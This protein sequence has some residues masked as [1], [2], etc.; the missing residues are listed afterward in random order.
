MR[1]SFH[2]RLILA[3]LAASCVLAAQVA[4]SR[5]IGPPDLADPPKPAQPQPATQPQNAPP[6]GA[7]RLTDS[8]A[9]IMPNASLTEM[10][11]LLAKRLKI[12][13]ILDPAV[14][15]TVSIFTYGEVKP[16]DYMP[17]LETI[18]RVNGSAMVKV[19]DIYRIVPVNRINQL[20]L[21]P[22]VNIDPKTLPDDERMVMN[23]IFLK[24]ATAAEI[25][26]LVKPFLGEGAFVSV[27]EPANLLLIE[28]NARSMK[29]TMDLIALFDSDQ[30]AGQR[31]RLFEVENSRPSDLQHELDLVFKA[32]ALSD[33]AAGSVK[34]IPVDRINT[35][36]AVAP[37]PGIFTQV[38]NWIGKLDIA[39]KASSGSVNTYVYR[40]KYA[41]A[42]TIAMAIMALYSGNP[43]ALMALGQMASQQNMGAGNGMGGM[44]GGQFGGQMGGG[45][46]YQMMGAMMGGGMG[47]P[48]LGMGGYGYGNQGMGMGGYPQIQQAS[49][50][51]AGVNIPG[52]ANSPI[53]QTGE[54]LGAGMAGGQGN[55][56]VPHVI[57]NPFDNTILIQGTPQEYGQILGLLR[58]LDIPPRQV[59]IDAKIYE[60]DLNGAF[61]A[62]VTAYLE[63]KN[64]GEGGAAARILKAATGAGGVALTTGAL[65]LRSH[66]LLAA[67]TASETKSHTR[68]ISAPSIIATDSIP[69][70]L[71]VGEDVPVLTAQAVGGVQQGGNSLFTNTVSNRSSGVTL[72]ITARINSSGIVTMQINQNVSSPQAPAASSSIQSPSFSNRSFQTQITVQDGDTVAIGGIIQESNLQ[73]SAGVPFLH[74]LPG[75]GALFGAQ[76]VT[77]TRTELVV[78]LTPRVIYDTNQMVEATD[79]IRS[80]MKKIQKM[81]KDE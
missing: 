49:P 53:G 18:L 59:L 61:A 52:T 29:R 19:G 50:L 39:V 65:V 47:Y 54:Y 27:Y 17:L 5:I 25:Q 12:N 70:S 62:G 20:P 31:V 35:I 3:A 37:N 8:G 43:F 80:S 73:S 34:F 45:G 64:T 48:S 26:N 69:A 57:P 58:Q 22:M 7:P 10:I 11:D 78:F 28:D 56:R 74:R 36:I 38:E 41:R 55:Q 71:N 77:K 63:K 40:L 6:T 68:V 15:G 75:I 1:L 32:Y 2:L 67:L 79:E 72:N 21:S 30:F 16:V 66:E 9:F 23:L 4:P 14:R 13:Y 81:V 24:Y 76:S 44:M 33:K 60:V 42:D 51:A 46:T